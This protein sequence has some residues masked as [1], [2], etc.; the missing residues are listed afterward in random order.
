MAGLLLAL[1]GPIL[2]LLFQRGHF[3]DADTMLFS[4]AL[5]WLVP[6]IIFCIGRDLTTRVFYAHH[7]SVTPYRIAVV[8]IFAKAILDWLLI[9]PLGVGGISLSTTIT[10]MLSMV[11]LISLL[12]IKIGS[13]GLTQLTKPF[14]IMLFG[15]LLAGC[16]AYFLEA[17]ISS[18]IGHATLVARLMALGSASSIAVVVYIACC[19]GF[20]L[21]E[22]LVVLKRLRSRKSRQVI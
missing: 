8:A 7:D 4:Q 21:D 5:V 15:S 16:T 14:L 13:L 19:L 17:G 6:S 12:G 18:H 10:T 9:K 1:P 3:S 11:C 20:R 2:S 22:P